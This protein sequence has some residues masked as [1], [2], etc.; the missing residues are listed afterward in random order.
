MS[1]PRSSPRSPRSTSLVV[2]F[3]E[4]IAP[5]SITAGAFTQPTRLTTDHRDAHRRQPG[6]ARARCWDAPAS[7]QGYPLPSTRPSPTCRALALAAGSLPTL[8]IQPEPRGRDPDQRGRAE[9]HGNRSRR[10]HRAPRH[11]RRLDDRPHG[12]RRRRHRPR[13]PAGPCWRPSPERVRRIGGYH[14]APPSPPRTPPGTLPPASEL[15]G[16]NQYP[17]R[18]LL[19]E[20]RRRVGLQ[21]RHERHCPSPTVRSSSSPRPSV[22]LP[23]SCSMPAAFSTQTALACAPGHVH[24]D[25]RLQGAARAIQTA[26]HGCRPARSPAA[27]TRRNPNTAVSVSAGWAGVGVTPTGNTVA[28]NA[29]GT[30]TNAAA[31]W[32]VGPS[33][34]GGPN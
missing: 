7:G 17:D 27:T 29:A 28:R 2:T 10:S 9:R 34:L 23:R 3:S 6:D 5:S 14:R 19:G 21:R 13:R 4:D 16:K 18:D 24:D 20:L 30:D 1:V 33:T 8:R 15:T 26:T 12:S 22:R 25:V 32:T 11:E 31:D